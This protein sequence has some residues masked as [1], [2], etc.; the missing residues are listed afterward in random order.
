MKIKIRGF[1]KGNFVPLMP[2]EGPQK[3]ARLFGVEE[4]GK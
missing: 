4:E 1:H 2:Q 3:V